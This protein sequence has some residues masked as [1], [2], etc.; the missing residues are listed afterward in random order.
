MPNWVW[1]VIVALVIVGGILYPLMWTASS[2]DDLEEAFE[3]ARRAEP[4]GPSPIRVLEG[5]DLPL[6]PRFDPDTLALSPRVHHPMPKDFTHAVFGPVEA[7]GCNKG[8]RVL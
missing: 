7:C 1:F 4:S 3:R 8:R 2:E 6:G 5:I